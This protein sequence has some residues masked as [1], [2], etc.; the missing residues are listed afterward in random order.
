MKKYD[1]IFSIGEACPC[2]QTLRQ[3]GLQDA[4]YPFDWLFGSTFVGRCKILADEFKDF[5]KKEDLQFSHEV[6]SLR[7]N[8]YYNKT[9]DITFMHDFLKS[10]DFEEA[11]PL[12]KEK[13]DRRIRR[14]LEKIKNANSVLVVYLENPTSNHIEIS[15]Q[16]ILQGYSILREKFGDKI[17]LLYIKN[18]KCETKV[19]ELE[20]G[21]V[22]K[23]IGDYKKYDSN[24]DYKVKKSKIISIFY[25]IGFNRWFYVCKNEFL[26]F[27]IKKLV[28]FE[29][30]KEKWLKSL[31]L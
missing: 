23:V 19:E 4:S 7:C 28:P 13:Y 11:Y 6:K 5:I 8:A 9:T 12:V 26:C 25:K 15:N 10:L 2:T 21:K 14:L 3:L 31:H 22:I 20:S 30:L 24:L 18:S 16:E 27:V 1:F 29:T 17:N